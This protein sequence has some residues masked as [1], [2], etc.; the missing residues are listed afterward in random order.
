MCF[1]EPDNSAKVKK[2]EFIEIDEANVE[3]GSG[4]P[5]R[6]NSA[7]LKAVGTQSG[8][9]AASYLCPQSWN[10]KGYGRVGLKER[11]YLN[12]PFEMT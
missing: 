7:A 10:N 11:G 5:R 8:C 6:L 1:K 2:N 12:R 3:R 4:N 9:P